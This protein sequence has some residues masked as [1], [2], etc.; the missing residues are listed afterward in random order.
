MGGICDRVNRDGAASAT[1]AAGLSDFG[2]LWPDPGFVP[3]LE[4]RI[5]GKNMLAKGGIEMAK[6]S[7][8]SEKEAKTS[9]E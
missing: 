6:L 2:T 3:P 4:R 5:Y 7:D 9:D 1:R 8:N